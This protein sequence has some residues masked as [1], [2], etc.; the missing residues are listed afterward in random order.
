MDGSM[1]IFIGRRLWAAVARHTGM[2]QCMQ[3]AGVNVYTG[4]K[5]GKLNMW[6]GRRFDKIN[7]WNM[8]KQ[9][10]LP[11]PARNRLRAVDILGGKLIVGTIA[12]EISIIDIASHNMVSVVHSAHHGDWKDKHAYGELWGLTPVPGQKMVFT[13]GDD[14]TVRCWDIVNRK[15]KSSEDLF[16]QAICLSCSPNGMDVAVGFKDGSFSVMAT[17]DM[18]ESIRVR[19]F[20]QRVTC[21]KFSPDGSYLAVGSADSTI[22]IFDVSDEYSLMA[23][24]RGHSSTITHLDWCSH[25]KYLQTTS[26]GCELLFYERDGT[27]VTRSRSLK[28]VEWA[29]QECTFGWNVQGIWPKYSDATDV[30]MLALSNSRK[31]LA[32]AEDSG[33]IKVYNYP[34]IGSGLDRRGKLRYRPDSF[35]GYGHSEHVTNVAWLSDDSYVMSTGGADLCVMQ[36]KVV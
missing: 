24:C 32:S 30:N 29:T 2:I 36:W 20:R 7:S 26:A 14:A 23:R 3:C 22:C 17:D 15:M 18:T 35:R 25:S 31:Y 34:C 11:T 12:G 8:N 13:C 21:I 10:E 19:Q 1:D 27:Q 16:C 33:C 28:D 9:K 6:D 4:G 5:D